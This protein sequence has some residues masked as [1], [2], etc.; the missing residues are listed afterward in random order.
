MGRVAK[1]KKVKSFDRAH[2][3]GEYVWGKNDG[4]QTKKKR[5]KQ[6]TTKTPFVENL[7]AIIINSL[8]KVNVL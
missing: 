7:F 1:Y 3:G 5:S 2:S 4:R 6:A 8:I